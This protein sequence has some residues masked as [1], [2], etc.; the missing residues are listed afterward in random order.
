VLPLRRI[1]LRRDGSAADEPLAD[2]LSPAEVER[3][4]A[5]G[6]SIRVGFTHLYS[7]GTQRATQ[8]LASML[9]GM[10][11]QVLEGV[12]VRAGL[13]ARSAAG[14]AEAAEEIRRI[15]R[16]IPE[17]SYALA[18]VGGD[19]LARAALGLSGKAPGVF[20][21]FEGFRVAEQKA[22]RLDLEPVRNEP[23]SG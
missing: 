14:P 8:T 7:G 22:G 19:V 17:G 2:A 1:E 9:A 10:G 21:P 12:V 11:R 3:A 18:V 15:L 20:G 5:L 23:G 16:E 6:R 13:G 4:H